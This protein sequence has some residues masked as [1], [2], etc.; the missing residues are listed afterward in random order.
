MNSFNDQ[1]F[2]ADI[3]KR[4]EE[5]FLNTTKISNNTEKENKMINIS[6]FNNI[7][8]I[9]LSMEWEVQMIFYQNI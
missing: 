6:P 4:L 3:E 5:I 7:R 2:N 9:L 1:K 8:K